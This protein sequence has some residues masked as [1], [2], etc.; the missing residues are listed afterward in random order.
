MKQRMNCNEDEFILYI[1]VGIRED[2][3]DDATA[4][5]HPL[6]NDLRQ[7]IEDC[8]KIVENA[9]NDIEEIRTKHPSWHDRLESSDTR[10]NAKRNSILMSVIAD[11]SFDGKICR[12]CGCSN[13]LYRCI[14]C[15]SSFL[16]GPCDSNVHLKQPFHDRDALF[17]GF[18]KPIA[19]ETYQ[20]NDGSF[21][22]R[23]NI[24]FYC[25]KLSSDPKIDVIK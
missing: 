6:S 18:W 22:T 15:C 19:P 7:T 8:V 16:C 11:E 24:T 12:I 1:F 21:E 20:N 13:V 5:E 14:D 17:D 4:V 3:Y 10:W 23:G 2:D 9:A 25:Y